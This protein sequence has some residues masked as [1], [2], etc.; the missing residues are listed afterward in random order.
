LTS[1]RVPAK[2][3]EENSKS[4]AKDRQADAM[5]MLDLAMLDMMKILHDVVC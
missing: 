2:D 1:S 4:T 3:G 5:K